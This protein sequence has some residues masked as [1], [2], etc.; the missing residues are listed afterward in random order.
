MD[1]IKSTLQALWEVVV[2]VFTWGLSLLWTLLSWIYTAC[3]W[4][5]ITGFAIFFLIGLYYIIKAICTRS[6][7][8]KWRNLKEIEKEHR[9]LQKTLARKNIRGWEENIQAINEQLFKE[10]DEK[11]RCEK[12]LADLNLSLAE[13]ERTKDDI[14]KLAHS[15]DQA[16]HEKRRLA[17]IQTIKNE[18]AKC[19]AYIAQFNDVCVKTKLEYR[20]LK[21]KINTAAFDPSSNY[22]KE[23]LDHLKNSIDQ[24]E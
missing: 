12:R 18:Q 1:S 20:N 16:E 17:D 24:V 3:F 5:L 4:I 22:L 6:H 8:K 14:A 7:R 15:Y 21:T 23:S 11:E 19:L 2:N 9:R 10:R 13:C